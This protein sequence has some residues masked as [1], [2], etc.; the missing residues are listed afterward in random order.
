MY[1]FADTIYSI[2]VE[3]ILSHCTNISDFCSTCLALSDIIALHMTAD[4]VT[5]D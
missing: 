4:F 1:I 5:T 2:K 3:L